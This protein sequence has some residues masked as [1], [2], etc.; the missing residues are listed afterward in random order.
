MRC[1]KYRFTGSNGLALGIHN[2]SG[3]TVLVIY[4]NF[5]NVF[6]CFIDSI[7]FFFDNRL[8]FKQANTLESHFL[9][10]FPHRKTPTCIYSDLCV[11]SE[12]TIAGI[13][14]AVS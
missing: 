8:A 6:A 7:A 1:G 13:L 2:F 9:A 5:Y 11:F 12:T 14:G 4:M 3:F 10:S